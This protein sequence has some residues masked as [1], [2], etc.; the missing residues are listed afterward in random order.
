MPGRLDSWRLV[1]R[2]RD[3]YDRYDEATVTSMLWNLFDYASDLDENQIHPRDE[4]REW[5]VDFDTESKCRETWRQAIAST[6]V[7]HFD[8]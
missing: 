4:A 8:E 2:L 6:R 3:H 7:R 1:V 5:A